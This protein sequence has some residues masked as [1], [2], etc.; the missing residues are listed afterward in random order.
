MVREALERAIRLELLRRWARDKSEFCPK[1]LV[2][3]LRQVV[4][5]E[6]GRGTGVSSTWANEPREPSA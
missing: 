1:L 2:R 3:C 4:E 6:V 5:A